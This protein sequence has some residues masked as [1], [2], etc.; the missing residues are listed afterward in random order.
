MKCPE[1]YSD[2]PRVTPLLDPEHCLRNHVQ[3]IC[4]TCGRHICINTDEAGRYRWKFPFRTLE[5]AKLYLKTAEIV[6]KDICGI[7]EI[8]NNKGRKSYKIF[9][10]HN[11]LIDYLKRN[12]DKKCELMEPMYISEKYTLVNDGQIRRLNEAEVEKYLKEQVQAS[13]V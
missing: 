10:G 12:P 8:R 7:Y 3:Y 9:H 4:S 6:C 13:I 1:C 11:D 2:K 5:I